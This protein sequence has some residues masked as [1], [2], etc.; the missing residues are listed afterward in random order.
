MQ[1][2]VE[3]PQEPAKVSQPQ[4]NSVNTPSPQPPPYWWNCAVGRAVRLLLLAVTVCVLWLTIENRWWGNF[5]L[6][7]RYEADAHYV[8]GMM[9]LAHI[10]TDSLGAPFTGQLNDWPE[11][12]RALIW[13]GGQIARLTGLIPAAN[14]MLIL[15]CIVAALSFYS[16]LR[17]WKVSRLPSWLFAVTYAFLPHSFRSLNHIGI[18]FTGLLPLQLYV[19]WYIA[20]AQN[21]YWK[22]WRFRLTI[23]MSLLSGLLN[24]YW[25]FLFLQLYVLVLLYRLIRRRKDFLNASIPFVGTCLVAGI[26]L[27]SFIIYKISYGENLVAVTRSYFDVERF[28]LKPVDLFI[29]GRAASFGALS[30]VFSRYHGAAIHIGEGWGSYIGLC[31]G[32]GLLFLLAEGMLRQASKRSP[33]LPYLA[34]IWIIAYISFGGINSIFSLV[35]DSYNIRGS[36]RYSVALATIG[37]VYFAFIAFRLTLAWPV[38]L[39]API[40]VLVALFGLSEQGWRSYNFSYKLISPYRMHDV[41]SQDQALASRLEDHLALGSMLFI[42]PATDFPEPFYGRGAYAA[43]FDYYDGM[44]PFLYSTKLRYSYGSHKGREGADWQLDVQELAAG[45]I[46]RVLE[47]YGFAGILLNRK[48]YKDR[49]EALLAELTEAGWPMEFEQGI[50][51]E[52][53]FI[54]LTPVEEPVLPTLTPYAPVRVDRK[55]YPMIPKF[56]IPQ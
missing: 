56:L 3:S 13:L 38:L 44:R 2:L 41:I 10:Y 37:L 49:G 46:A 53:V 52:W 21:L 32:F 18:I 24:I 25:I 7:T 9:K 34:A 33:S 27:I 12:Q 17:L 6:P 31:A 48:G 51:N 4:E 28:S 20:A 54:R 1:T 26:F 11:T 23:V 16:A 42:L 47:S 22:S 5:Q 55:A 14:I 40:L 35:F 36:N 8:L 43:D 39:R 29:P 45:E 30:D 50:D 15:S 19:L